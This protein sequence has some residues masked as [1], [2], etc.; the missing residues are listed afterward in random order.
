VKLDRGQVRRALLAAQGLCGER[1][2]EPP[3]SEDVL[4]AIR[5]MHALQIDTISVVAR[6]PYLVLWSRLGPYAPKTLDALLESHAVFE[7]WSH[8]AC[9]LD[10]AD[11]P[12]YRRMML[13]GV[14]PAS[15]RREQWI[16]EH[17]ELCDGILARIRDEGPVRSADFERPAGER[18]S[19]WWDWKAE[20]I[21]LEFL[22]TRGDLM[23]TRRANFQRIYDLRERV[24]PAWDD[25][26]AP[27][28]EDAQRALV[29]RA[30]R[31]LGVARADWV[32]ANLLWIRA[33]TAATQ[34]RLEALA[35]EGE[36]IGCEVE[37]W[38]LPGYVHP[39]NVALLDDGPL[40][41]ARTTLLSPFDP[42]TWDRQRALELFDF[43]YKI[44]CYTPAA[45][46]KYG[47]FTLPILFD[48]A[49]V[50]RL[51]AKAH[52]KD[53][54]LEVKAVHLEPGVAVS[55]ELVEQ[56]AA[57]LREFGAWHGTPEVTVRES[58]PA[59]LAARLQARL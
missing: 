22:F 53:G 44:E 43:D 25:R 12:Y 1:P 47:Y 13:D 38:K 21:A 57:T 55:G 26:D 59:E 54:V 17:K 45:K 51:D 48:D 46:R 36:L 9:F 35:S 37:G 7:Y 56:L 6:S 41:E 2:T 20:K 14:M 15:K 30:A 18:G 24:M 33:G 28:L 31:S 49:L 10:A 58:N 27:P 50:G 19:G 5:G 32:N 52:R 34:R 42:I 23:V 11:Y 39:D 16:Q 40:P 8:A 29:L 4:G 3:G